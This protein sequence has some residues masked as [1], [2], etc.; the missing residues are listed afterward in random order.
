MSEAEAQS[1][2]G[3]LVAADFFFGGTGAGL[4]LVSVALG[5]YGLYGD[6]PE[7]GLII[8]LVFVVIGLLF[9]AIHEWERRTKLL[10]ILRR[11]GTS[12]ISRGTIFNIV[13]LL[14]GVLYAAPHWIG[15]VPWAQHSD[16]GYLVGA[17]AGLASFLVILYPGMFLSSLSSIPFWNS[18]FI[19]LLFISYGVTGALGMLSVVLPLVVVTSATATSD[20]LMLWQTVMVVVTV[21]LVASQ[22]IWASLAKPETKKSADELVRGRL[23]YPFAVGS[24]LVGLFIPLVASAFSYFTGDFLVSALAGA[25][26]L[27]GSVLHKYTVLRAGIYVQLVPDAWP[28]S[29][30]S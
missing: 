5:L 10:N 3:W 28:V 9:L 7:I 23:L 2:W 12:W 1:V 17:V 15:W 4:F 30:A 22:L 24:L 21:A 16:L 14:F 26:I 19:P 11:P 29:S 18:P 6:L 8:G 20:S 13:F 27:V 25:L